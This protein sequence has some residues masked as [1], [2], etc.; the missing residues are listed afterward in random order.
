MGVGAAMGTS[1]APVDGRVAGPKGKPATGEDG[2][3]A[4]SRG[5]GA[6]GTTCGAPGAPGLLGDGLLSPGLWTGLLAVGER[7][8]KPAIEPSLRAASC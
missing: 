5:P 1:A 8:A 6:A 3:G 4:G 2:T 7:L